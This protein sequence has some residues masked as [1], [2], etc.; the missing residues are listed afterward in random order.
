MAPAGGAFLAGVPT[1]AA[2][3][4]IRLSVLPRQS[5][6]TLSHPRNQKA[7]WLSPK[8]TNGPKASVKSSL[9]VG[10]SWELIYNTYSR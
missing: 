1:T 10:R 5:P 6:D 7:E 8:G 3:F 9:G 4:F 2:T